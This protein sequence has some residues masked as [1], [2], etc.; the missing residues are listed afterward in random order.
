MFNKN[1]YVNKSE[2][3]RQSRKGIFLGRIITIVANPAQKA[4]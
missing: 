4:G 3:Q 2:S 1:C